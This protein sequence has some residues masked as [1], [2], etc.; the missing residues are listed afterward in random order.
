MDSSAAQER[1]QL[2]QRIEELRQQGMCYTCHDQKTGELFSRQHVVYEDDLYRVALD[3]Y[4][5]MPGHTIV[6]YK[7]HREDLSEL[8]PEE[9]GKLFAFCVLVVQAIKEALG[10]EKVYLNTMCDGGINHLH[11]QLFPRY[12]RNGIGSTRF[13]LPREPVT[14]GEETASRIRQELLRLMEAKST[15]PG[16]GS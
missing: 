3:L 11:L 16:N 5:R 10:A 9:A 13:V 4:P 1:E 7:P 2:M 15:A 14:N 6:V 12:P 8:E